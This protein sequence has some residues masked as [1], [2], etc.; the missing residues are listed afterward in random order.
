MKGM[1]LLFVAVR[2]FPMSV[3]VLLVIASLRL[4]CFVQSPSVAINGPIHSELSARF[5]SSSC[6]LTTYVYYVRF[7]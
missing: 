5:I 4:I 1:L 6:T 2:S 3:K 7:V